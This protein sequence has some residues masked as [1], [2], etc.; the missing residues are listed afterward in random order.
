MKK[1]GFSLIELLVV[2]GIIA[3]LAAI[4]F[5]MLT[6]ARLQAYRTQC[7]SN[8]RQ[9]SNAI[10]IYSEQ[11]NGNTPCIPSPSWQWQWGAGTFRDTLLPYVKGNKKVFIC[12]VKTADQAVNGGQPAATRYTG[13]YGG[14]YYLFKD[15]KPYRE[16]IRLSEIPVPTKTIL[17]SENK[18]GDWSAEPFD[19]GATGDY[20]QF[21]PYHGTKALKGGL[22]M[23]CDGHAGFMS[24]YT[25]Q[26]TRNGIS[27]YW[28]QLK[29]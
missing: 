16:F 12:P 3:I 18:D 13:H 9:I 28:W 21:Y 20:G 11:N 17:V 2:I 15:S 5:P 24:V 25:T 27:Y 23:F 29:K 6:A 19:N 4:L 1:Q 26:E 10:M 22:F 14:N 7:L 8:I